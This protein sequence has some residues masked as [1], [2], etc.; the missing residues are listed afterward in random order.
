MNRIEAIE[1][2][3]NENENSIFIFSNGLTSRQAV[4]YFPLNNAIYL[5]HAMGEALSVGVGLATTNSNLS[6]VV[7]DGDG[8]SLM[9]MASWPLKLHAPNLKYYVI[10]NGIYE[11]TGGQQLIDFPCIPDWVKIIDINHEKF[12]T[13]NPPNPEIIYNNLAKYLKGVK[14]D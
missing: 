4:H 2:I 10:R 5:T 9:G 6:V 14:V 1:M 12:E 7:I 11:T 8:N 13:P 3:L